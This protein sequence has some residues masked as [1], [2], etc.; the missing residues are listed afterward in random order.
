[1]QRIHASGTRVLPAK[2]WTLV[3]MSGARQR[4]RIPCPLYVHC[5]S[6]RGLARIL[7]LWGGG[8]PASL[9]RNVQA[10]PPALALT[11]QDQHV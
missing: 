2:R 6:H 11:P 4:M 10:V 5:V 8:G 1:M 3:R 9:W 7:E